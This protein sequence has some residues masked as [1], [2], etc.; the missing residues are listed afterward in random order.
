MNEVARAVSAELLKL[1]RTLALRLAIGVPLAVVLLN[2]VVSSQQSNAP[3]PGQNPLVG[4]AQA[5]LMLWTL[6]VLPLYT[7]LTAALVAALDHQGD[8]WKHLLALPVA[9]RS[10]FCAKWVA[11]A[12]LLLVS[13]LVMSGTIWLGVQ[14]LHLIK[15]GWRSA[16]IPSVVILTRAMQSFCAALLALSIQWWVSLRWRSFIAGLA[17]GI[18]AVMVMLGGASRARNRATF[19]RLYPWAIPITTIARMMEPTRDRMLLAACGILGGLA[20]GGAGCWELSRR[21]YV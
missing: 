9:R 13:S 17:F 16:A 15:P 8:N 7:A 1:R 6:L 19:V 14:L 5:S 3:L 2:F 18:V 10:I 4:F 12:G 20:I 21:E 11:A